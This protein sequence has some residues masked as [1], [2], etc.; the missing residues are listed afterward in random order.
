MAEKTLNVKITL[1]YPYY[2][3]KLFDA[4]SAYSQFV[5]S[6]PP[7]KIKDLCKW[8]GDLDNCTANLKLA[9]LYFEKHRKVTSLQEPVTEPVPENA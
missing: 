1:D 7:A 5:N 9:A 3:L 6:E 2:A 4:A 8:Y